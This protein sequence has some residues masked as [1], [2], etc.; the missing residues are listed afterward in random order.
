MT[1]PKGPF[2]FRSCTVRVR[3][4]HKKGPFP[5]PCVN[6]LKASP[7]KICVFFYAYDEPPPSGGSSY[8]HGISLKKWHWVQTRRIRVTS[9]FEIACAPALRVL[10]PWLW[11]LLSLQFSAVESLGDELSYT[12]RNLRNTGSIMAGASHRHKG[13]KSSKKA[14]PPRARAS[15][16]AHR[17]CRPRSAAWLRV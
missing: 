5:R 15:R 1:A 14:Q 8:V 17:A 7:Q 10:L 16:A 11:A 12:R 6:Y 9:L 13:K 2:F 3:S 4:F